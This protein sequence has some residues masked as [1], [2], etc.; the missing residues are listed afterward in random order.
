MIQEYFLYEGFNNS[1]DVTLAFLII[2]I[3]KHFNLKAE[4]KKYAKV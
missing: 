2:R 1:Q 3:Y 4:E